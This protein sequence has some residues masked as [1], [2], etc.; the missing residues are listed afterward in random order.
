MLKMDHGNLAEKPTVK[1]VK[2]AKFD[3]R[4]VVHKENAPAG[5]VNKLNILIDDSWIHVSF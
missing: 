3:D 5:K 1:L 4:I 2:E